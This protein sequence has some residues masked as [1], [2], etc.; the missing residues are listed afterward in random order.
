[1]DNDFN[2][3]IGISVNNWLIELNNKKAFQWDAYRPLSQ[4]WGGGRSAQPP[5]NA[6]PIPP[7]MQTPTP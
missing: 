5:L 2:H 1:M 3:H 7:W 4:F 6:D